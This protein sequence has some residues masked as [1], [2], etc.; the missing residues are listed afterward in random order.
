[1]MSANFSPVIQAV[2]ISFLWQQEKM[3]QLCLSPIIP[4]V[5]LLP[6]KLF[7]LLTKLSALD[8]RCFPSPVFDPLGGMS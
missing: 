2:Q 8:F 6:S 3:W 7:R 4:S 1:M 5:K